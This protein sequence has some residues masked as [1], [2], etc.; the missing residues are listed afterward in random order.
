MPIFMDPHDL[1]G[2]TSEDV[3]AVHRKDLGI[4]DRYGVK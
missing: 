2:M 4:Q 1:R 3:A